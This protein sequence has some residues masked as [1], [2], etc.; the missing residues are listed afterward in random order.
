MARK[1]KH[2]EHVNHERWLI[3]YADFITLLF[4]FFVVMYSVSSV[5]EGKYRVVSSSLIAAFGAPVKS[6]AP[7]QMGELARAPKN[8]A[9]KQTI[10]A[11]ESSKPIPKPSL[12]ELL[13]MPDVMKGEGEK[14]G[15]G[16]DTGMQ[17]AAE[18]IA[19]ALKNLIRDEL[20]EV[21]RNGDRLEIEIKSSV[22]FSSGSGEVA[23]ESLPI[24]EVIAKIL[25]TLPNLIHVEGFTDDI[26]I[27]TITYPSNWELSAARAARVVRH[28][29]EDGLE[30]QRLVPMGFGQYRP[31]ATNKTA[32][33]RARNRR[34]V[35]VVMSKSAPLEGGSFVEA[36]DMPDERVASV[37]ASDVGEVLAAASL[38]TEPPVNDKPLDQTVESYRVEL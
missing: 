22:L 10:S 14:G 17:A 24:I 37:A 34:V 23:E 35:L 18:Q 32:E 27:S 29:V 1:E 30:P 9:P 21:R 5:N 31:V 15:D 36:M 7:I 8:V 12:E 26:P 6:L 19:E 3:S 16:D 11:V 13:G 38:N 33:G 4:A 20:V 25:D 2:E 28:L